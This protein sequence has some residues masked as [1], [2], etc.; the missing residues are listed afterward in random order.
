MATSAK[1]ALEDQA[2]GVEIAA[3]REDVVK[4]G[5]SWAAL[6]LAYETRPLSVAEMCE[7]VRLQEVTT[8]RARSKAFDAI[9]AAFEVF[10]DARARQKL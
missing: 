7:F 3:L 4:Y 10:D 1:Q 9:A 2:K 6:C 5:S 8:A